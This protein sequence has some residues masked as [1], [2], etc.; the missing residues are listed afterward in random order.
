MPIDPAAHK[1]RKK[2][3]KP[4]KERGK[5]GFSFLFFAVQKRNISLNWKRVQ[6]RRHHRLCIWQPSE[7]KDLKGKARVC[8][9]QLLDGQASIV[10]GREAERGQG[11]G[12]NLIQ[13][14]ISDGTSLHF[15]DQLSGVLKP[16]SSLT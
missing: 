13:W 6:H 9:V 7:T 5:E 14:Q 1:V 15:R 12:E 10:C 11:I 16:G 8:G 4:E 3:N 2:Q